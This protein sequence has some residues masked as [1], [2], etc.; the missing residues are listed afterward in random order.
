MKQIIIF[1]ELIISCNLSRSLI[2]P[3]MVILSIM[4]QAQAV[5]EEKHIGSLS[6]ARATAK[7]GSDLFKI[8]TKEKHNDNIVI[9]P[10]SIHIT[11]QIVMRGADIES[12]TYKEMEK[13]FEYDE[14]LRGTDKIH[15]TMDMLIKGLGPESLEGRIVHDAEENSRRPKAPTRLKIANVLLS[16]KHLGLLKDFK[17]SVSK[18]YDMKFDSFDASEANCIP[19]LYKDVNDWVS[20]K[21]EKTIKHILDENEISADTISVLMNAVYL[22]GEWMYPF[23]SAGSETFYN[24]GKKSDTIK[25]PFM[26]KERYY[27]YLDLRHNTGQSAYESK[28][29]L[30]YS[31]DCQV[32]SVPIDENGLSMIILLPDKLDGLSKFYDVRI[33]RVMEQ[34]RQSGNDTKVHLRLPKFSLD[35]K[36]DVKKYLEQLGMRK[37]VSHEPELYR[38]FDGANVEIDG[39]KHKA[40]INVTET[41][42]EASAATAQTILLLSLPVG[43][44]VKPIPFVADHP[45]MFAIVNSK[46]EVPLFMGQV[47]TL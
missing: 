46:Y 11:L 19:N 1:H 18:Y 26:Y 9:S 45:F 36:Y 39:I 33:S 4:N 31:L 22:R 16:R 29:Q 47:V 21:T 8:I 42:V 7:L 5:R 34:M 23:H 27:S 10:L 44:A 20:N 3:L 43:P 14:S 25:T 40:K 37:L 38:M 30:D 17:D 35:A 24:Y 12:Q 13:Y 2:Y 28:D 6:V 32:L 15:E 41:G